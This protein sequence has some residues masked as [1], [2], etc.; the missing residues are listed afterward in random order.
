MNALAIA[1]CQ[2]VYI[3]ALPTPNIEFKADRY[4]F[5]SEPPPPP[6]TALEGGH[7]ARGEHIGILNRPAYLGG[8]PTD[9]E[10]EGT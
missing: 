4:A 1:M 9:L 2:L 10:G 6:L 5:V 8:R 3:G 7:A